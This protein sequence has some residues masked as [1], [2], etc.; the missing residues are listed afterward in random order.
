MLD[1]EDL[2][3]WVADYGDATGGFFG[4]SG[5][6]KRVAL[7]VWF[8]PVV[9]TAG[10]CHMGLLDERYGVLEL[11]EGEGYLDKLRGILAG[12]DVDG[13]VECWERILGLG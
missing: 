9:D 11:L 13:T 10:T 12:A 1:V 8:I 4:E 7:E 5:V 3:I 2:Y 6:D